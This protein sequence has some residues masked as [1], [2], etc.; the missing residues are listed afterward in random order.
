MGF[1]I[2]I[3]YFIL[4]LWWANI[5][6]EYSLKVFIRSVFINH[7]ESQ[8]VVFFEMIYIRITLWFE[9]FMFNVFISSITNL[10]LF[11]SKRDTY[12]TEILVEKILLEFNHWLYVNFQFFC[13]LSKYSNRT[14][15]GIIHLPCDPQYYLLSV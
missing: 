8:A 5:G 14:I 11:L 10:Q 9:S 4:L 15:V 3:I 2:I 7:D 6:V 13:W 12:L 1:V